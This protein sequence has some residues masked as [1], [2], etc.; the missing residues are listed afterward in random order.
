MN[1][2]QT[3]VDAFYSTTDVSGRESDN[4]MNRIGIS[5]GGKGRLRKAIEAQV[6][7]EFQKELS[8]AVGDSQRA[9][10]EEKIRKEI[11]ERIARTASPYSLWSSWQ[12]WNM[13]RD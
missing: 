1:L 7:R 11:D 3:G 9:A 6:R 8:A 5:V 2:R 4:E 12:F 13:P 10:I